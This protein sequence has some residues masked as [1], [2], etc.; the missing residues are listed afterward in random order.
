M[1]KQEAII[2]LHY[3]GKTN[4]VIIKLSKMCKSMIHHVVNR[5]TEVGTSEDHL[6]N[7]RP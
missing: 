6:R 2:K 7:G 5:F 1:S 3:V 4:S